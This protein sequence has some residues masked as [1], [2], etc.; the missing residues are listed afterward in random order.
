M[1]QK[2]SGAY[3]RYHKI[4]ITTNIYIYI[5]I[6]IYTCPTWMYAPTYSDTQSY[7]HVQQCASWVDRFALLRH[8]TCNC[9]LTSIT[10]LPCQVEM[11]NSQRRQTKGN[12]HGKTHDL[13][14]TSPNLPSNPS[15]SRRHIFARGDLRSTAP[16]KTSIH[17]QGL[18]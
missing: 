9:S 14:I 3:K 7:V 15:P 12:I 8:A 13:S 1:H 17:V 16:L 10:T 11:K 2:L 6:Y 18:S 5:C 4:H